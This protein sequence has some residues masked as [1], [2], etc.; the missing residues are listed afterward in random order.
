MWSRVRQCCRS[1]ALVRQGSRTCKRITLSPPL[2][3]DLASGFQP[4]DRQRWTRFDDLPWV[5]SAGSWPSDGVMVCNACDTSLTPCFRACWLCCWL[6]VQ[7][8]AI[9]LECTLMQRRIFQLKA[10][11]APTRLVLQPMTKHA[12]NFLGHCMHTLQPATP[13]DH[14]EVGNC[15]AQVSLVG[16]EGL[17]G[18]FASDRVSVSICVA[19]Y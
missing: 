18:V 12:L 3:A 1:A 6:S 11:K 16:R 15:A 2:P 14:K 8:T 17:N 7:S 9:K 19:Q 13:G 10:A 4:G 5:H